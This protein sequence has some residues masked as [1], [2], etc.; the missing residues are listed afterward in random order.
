MSKTYPATLS[1]FVG[2]ERNANKGTEEGQTSLRKSVQEL[3]AGRSLVADKHGTLI[4]GNKTKEA[5]EA[6]GITGVVVV[7]T[8]GTE[9][10]IVKRTDMDLEDLQGSARQYAY[11]DNRVGQVSLS[12]DA[13][14]IAADI[15]AGVE[16]DD[17]FDDKV[18]KKI[19]SGLEEPEGQ[20]TDGGEVDLADELLEKWGVKRGQIWQAGPHRV[21][22]GDSTDRRDVEALAD[23]VKANMVWTDP[24]YGVKYGDKLKANNEMGYKVRKIENDD[25]SADQLE[26]LIREA[27]TNAAAV[28]VPGAAIYAACPAGRPLV[29]ALAAFEGS[30]FEFRW[31]LVWIKDQLVLSRADY[32]F[33]HENIL[34]GWKPDG[35]HH[36]TADRTQDSVFEVPRPKRSEEHPTMKPPDLIV[37]MIRNSSIRGGVVYEPFCGSG[38]TLVACDMTRRVGMGID[39][40]PKYVAVTL[41]RLSKAGQ[42]PKLVGE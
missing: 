35:P 4:A 28:T 31:Q 33:R 2:D 3:G 10:V 29:A 40:E 34:Y 9:V 5:L 30:G 26:Q 18:L 36:F 32:H 41:E 23:G 21:M 16:L 19:L 11:L 14:Q 27:Y 42:D 39:L 17:I 24:P 38:S 12:W 6:E 7:E 1:E 25:L 15:E 8:D 13:E 20:S 37:A 22:C